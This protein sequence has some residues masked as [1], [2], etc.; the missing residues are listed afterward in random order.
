MRRLF[1]V[2]M[3][4]LALAGGAWW[5]HRPA[6][7]APVNASR[8]ENGM[9]EGLVRGILPELATNRMPVVFLAFGDGTTPPSQAFIAR[10]AGSR[11]EVRSCG[12]SVN[13]PTG[14]YFE[15]STGKPG[16]LV[17]VIR[18]KQIIPGAF[19]VIVRFSNLP[20]GHDQFAYRISDLT[21]QWT[22]E[23]RKPA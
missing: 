10:F 20:A 12:S 16:M 6:Y 22:I 4:G 3:V 2:L 14:Q 18:F 19:D 5:L 21:G 15:V 9:V 1:I 23:S 11:P 17:H 8:Y 13:P 7:P